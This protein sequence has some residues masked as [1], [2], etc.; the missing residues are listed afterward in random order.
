MNRHCIT[1]VVGDNGKWRDAKI[2]K[3]VER[4]PGIFN[5]HTASLANPSL[6]HEGVI[7]YIDDSHVFQQAGKAIIMHNKNK[8]DFTPKLGSVSKLIYLEGRAFT[9]V[10]QT[11][12]RRK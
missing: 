11:T 8:F 10:S 6:T 3:A 4:P 2:E 7:L 5:L 12:R 9:I 1:Q